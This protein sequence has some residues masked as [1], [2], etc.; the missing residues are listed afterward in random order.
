MLPRAMS[1]RSAASTRQLLELVGE[2]YG[3]ENLDEFRPGILE[4]RVLDGIHVLTSYA[5]LCRTV[6]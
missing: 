5:D 1:G 6:S 4:V 3:F 2:A